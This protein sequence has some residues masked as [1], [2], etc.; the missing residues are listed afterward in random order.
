MRR[1]HL[2][3][4]VFGYRLNLFRCSYD[5]IVRIFDK[6]KFG[7]PLQSHD[8]GGGVWRV[9]WHPTRSHRLLT[10]CMHDGFK[11]LDYPADFATC[12][13]SVRFDEHGKDALA[14]GS[15]WATTKVDGKSLIATCS[16]YDHQLR[17][18]ST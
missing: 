9:R 15:D 11:V 18:W 10:A 3:P 7:T 1:L 12:E 16:F 5:G 13:T 2:S 4:P 6:R 14:Y 17:S 8:V